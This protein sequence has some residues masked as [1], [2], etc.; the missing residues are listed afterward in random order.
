MNLKEPAGLAQLAPGTKLE[1]RENVNGRWWLE[2]GASGPNASGLMEWAVNDLEPDG[3][4]EI[5]LVYEVSAP[6]G[7]KW[8]QT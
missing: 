1:L 8:T 3:S 7:V 5:K 2:D 4:E 6:D